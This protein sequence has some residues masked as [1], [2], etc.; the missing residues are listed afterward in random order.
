MTR[1]QLCV[2]CFERA[3]PAVVHTPPRSKPTPTGTQQAN[4]PHPQLKSQCCTYSL[5][6]HVFLW[7]ASCI[8]GAR[9]QFGTAIYSWHE[10]CSYRS[11][12]KER[13]QEGCYQIQEAENV[14]GITTCVHK[15]QK[16]RQEIV[17]MT[18]SQAQYLVTILQLQHKPAEQ[19]DEQQQRIC[20]TPMIR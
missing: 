19:R 9:A 15:R 1:A 12:L 6:T 3:A 14:K 4:I 17:R 10:F 11:D 2:L 16:I 20:K 13:F 5:Q 18:C 7:P 8:L